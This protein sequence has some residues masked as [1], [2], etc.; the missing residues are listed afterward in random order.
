M[1]E[2][3]ARNIGENRPACFTMTTPC[4]TSVLTLQFLAK[5]KMAVIPHLPYSPDLAPR[6]FFLF[7]KMKLKMKGCRFHTT[8]EIQAESHRVSNT[9][10]K[11][12]PGIVPK[13]EETVGPVST[14]GREVLRG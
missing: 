12:L 9:N 11:G 5:N 8:E 1:C 7:P 3:I 4:H 14:C 10:R 2:D 13:M 6:D